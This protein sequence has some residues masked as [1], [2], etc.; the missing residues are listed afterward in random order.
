MHLACMC[1]RA[2]IPLQ[3][4]AYIS[5]ESSGFWRK[6]KAMKLSIM[7]G[8]LPKGVIMFGNL[9]KRSI[10]KMGAFG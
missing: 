3:M 2:H 1:A 9:A 7:F 8:N 10:R 5:I 6:N 4:R